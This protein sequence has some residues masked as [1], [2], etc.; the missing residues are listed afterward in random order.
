M[1]FKEIGER[2]SLTKERI[3]QIE[4]RAIEKLRAY[5]D[6]KD[7]GVFSEACYR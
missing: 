7:V 1:S 4:K 2:Y 6:E 3:R 5:S